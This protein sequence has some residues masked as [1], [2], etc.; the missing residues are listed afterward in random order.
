MRISPAKVCY[1]LRIGAAAPLPADRLAAVGDSAKM[2]KEIVTKKQKRAN[3]PA[4][5]FPVP[6]PYEA[7]LEESSAL[8]FL[9]ALLFVQK[10]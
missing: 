4:R 6:A 8:L 9:Q 1:E 5:R 10:M 3:L 2:P 7:G